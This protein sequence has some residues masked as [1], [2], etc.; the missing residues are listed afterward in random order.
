[1]LYV[2]L[3]IIIVA[4]IVEVLTADMLSIWFAG[5]GFLAMITSAV[6]LPPVVQIIVFVVVSVAL[7]LVF[8][9]LVL[10]KLMKNKSNLNAD[11]AIGKE[12]MLLS[13]V[14]FNSPGA[15]KVNDVVWSAVC[16]DQSTTIPEN[17]KVKVIGLKGNKY[18]V[19][20]VK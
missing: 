3:A 14:G 11:S 1:M 9:K 19:E 13:G 4:I 20:E 7:L 16:E 17:T 12:F 2:W 10:K 15:I 6:K 8:R 5:G 18:I